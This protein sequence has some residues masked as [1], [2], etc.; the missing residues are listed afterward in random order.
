MENVKNNIELNFDGKIVPCLFGLSFI[1]TDHGS[2][3][4]NV[5]QLL[6]SIMTEPFK[7]VPKLL[8]ESY[9]HHCSRNSI[10]SRY[11]LEDIYDM[12]DQDGGISAP[13]GNTSKFTTAFSKYLSRDLDNSLSAPEEQPKVNE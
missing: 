1:A 4:M 12:I 6:E 2:L 11:S 5:D 8:H 9:L 13:D 10:Q 7:T 3:N